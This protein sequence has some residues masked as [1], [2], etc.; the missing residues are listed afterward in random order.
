VPARGGRLGVYGEFVR[1]TGVSRDGNVP[2]VASDLSRQTVLLIGY[3][4]DRERSR[5]WRL[6]VAADVLWRN[7]GPSSSSSTL[8]CVPRGIGDLGVTSA[9][10]EGRGSS[11]LL[12]V[13]WVAAVSCGAEA[14]IGE[15]RMD[16]DA[17]ERELLTRSYGNYPNPKD[18]TTFYEVRADGLYLHKCP[19]C[20]VDP[21]TCPDGFLLYSPVW[22][23]CKYADEA[24]ASGDADEREGYNDLSKYP[25]RR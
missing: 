1:K 22:D 10:V 4:A 3:V 19:R 13:G 8:E 20:N 5:A 15:S 17:Y 11:V 21:S 23:L 24:N 25:R 14:T 9:E 7:F 18:S 16:V 12:S 2:R 6:R